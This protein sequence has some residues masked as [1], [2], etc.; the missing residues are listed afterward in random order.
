MADV[1]A[2]AVRG[3][4][5]TGATYQLKHDPKLRRARAR[6]ANARAEKCMPCA[7]GAYVHGLSKAFGGGGGKKK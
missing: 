1:I 5:Y 2:M 6:A 4:A 7:A 3:V